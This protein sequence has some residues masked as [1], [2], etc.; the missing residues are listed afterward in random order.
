MGCDGGAWGRGCD[1]GSGI[2]QHEICAG[3]RTAEVAGL[4]GGSAVCDLV[5]ALVC[6]GGARDSRGE[7]QY[8]ERCSGEGRWSAAPHPTTTFALLT[9]TAPV[10]SVRVTLASTLGLS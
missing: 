1:R 9:T 6:V 4:G 10:A 7:C 5:V 2:G 8:A 3:E